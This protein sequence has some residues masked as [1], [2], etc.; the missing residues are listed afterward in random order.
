MLYNSWVI[1]NPSSI[2]CRTL[3]TEHAACLC[4]H[5][6]LFS[7]PPLHHSESLANVRRLPNLHGQAHSSM[8]SAFEP[9]LSYAANMRPL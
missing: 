2:R 7:R 6:L 3:A 9:S 1:L 5:N 4:Y 8:L